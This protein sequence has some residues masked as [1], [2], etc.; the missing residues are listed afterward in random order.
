LTVILIVGAGLLLKSF[1]LLQQTNLGLNPHNALM[2]DLIVSK[3][4][5]D[6]ERRATFL[7]DILDSVGSLPGVQDVAVH[8][9][10]PFLGVGR[11]NLSTWRVSRTP[12]PNTWHIVAFNVVS[13]DFFAAMG[14]PMRR[15]RAIDKR[16][17]ASALPV[18]VVNEAVARQFWPSADPIGK[19]IRLYYDKD[20]QHWLS[21]VGI[22]GDVR[23]RGRDLEP[24]PQ[25]FVPY[26][27]NPYE[28]FRT[29]RAH[30]LRWSSGPLRIQQT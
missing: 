10:P 2:A 8:T 27:Q 9:D 11:K 21:V 29:R 4:Y 25:V 19:R 24:V 16:D 13:N 26:Q 23:Y 20:P 6:P 14:I 5:A 18:V 12:A 15:G 7:R 1:V 17:T 22:V 30:I 3:R 28:R